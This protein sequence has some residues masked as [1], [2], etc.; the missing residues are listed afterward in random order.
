MAGKGYRL[1]REEA[2]WRRETSRQGKPKARKGR[3]RQRPDTTTARAA[4]PAHNRTER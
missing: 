3:S 2:L 4:R 1:L